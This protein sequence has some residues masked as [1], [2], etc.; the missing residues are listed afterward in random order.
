MMRGIMRYNANRKL[1]VF[2][3]IVAII[4]TF[5]LPI[6]HVHGQDTNYYVGGTGASDSNPGTSSLPFATIQKAASIA[7]SGSIVNIRAGTYR[8]TITPANSGVTFQPD[9]V[10]TVVVSGLVPELSCAIPFSFLRL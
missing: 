3:M 2:V 8:E 6:Q 5:I 9:G 1:S 4:I 7:V 10:A